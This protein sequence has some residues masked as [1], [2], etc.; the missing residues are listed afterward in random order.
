MTASAVIVGELLEVGH[1]DD[2]IE[3]DS[4]DGVAGATIRRGELDGDG[5]GPLAE[6]LNREVL[7]VTIASLLAVFDV[8]DSLLAINRI[9]GEVHAIFVKLLV[10][11]EEHVCRG[12]FCLPEEH[13]DH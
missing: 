10:A 13:F 8:E 11:H 4:V 5:V 12:H 1:R 9:D 3:R 6:G 7:G 2:L